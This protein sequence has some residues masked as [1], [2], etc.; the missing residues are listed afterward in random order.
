[1]TMTELEALEAIRNILSGFDPETSPLAKAFEGCCE[2]A[3]E[4]IENGFLDSYKERAEAWEE[5]C[6]VEERRRIQALEEIKRLKT[7]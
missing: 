3:Q 4:N 2:M 7:K 5:D 1:M 6:H